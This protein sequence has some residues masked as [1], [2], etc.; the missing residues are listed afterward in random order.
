VIAQQHERNIAESR[1]RHEIIEKVIKPVCGDLLD[2]AVPPLINSAGSFVTGGPEADTGVTGRK[3]IADTY[4]GMARHGGGSFSGKDPTKV[5]RSGAYLCRYAAKNVVAAG[6]ARRCEVQLSY[7][8]GTPEPVSLSVDT[9]GTGA[10]ADGRIEEL[11]RAH[12]PLTPREI[13]SRLDLRRPVYRKTAA[14]GAFGRE[15]PD[16][17]W[18]KTDVAEALKREAR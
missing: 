3:I 11:I 4:G 15:E 14:Y 5:D 2:P 10:C 7:A 17:T 13:I 6:L 12:F 16:F 8:I 18:E 9:F 1:L